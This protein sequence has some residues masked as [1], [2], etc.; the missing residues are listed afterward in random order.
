MLKRPATN[1]N[2]KI[3]TK[4]AARRPYTPIL[5]SELAAGGTTAGN[6]AAHTSDWPAMVTFIAQH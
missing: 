2:R 3:A 5:P 4:E 6:N 1:D